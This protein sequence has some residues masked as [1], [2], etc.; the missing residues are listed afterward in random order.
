MVNHYISKMKKHF[1]ILLISVV[2]FSCK[3][4]NERTSY[5]YQ[6]DPSIIQD[7]YGRQL[8]FHGLN[9]ANISKSDSLRNPWIIE[10]DVER[11]AT[12]FGFNF[13]RYLIFWDAIEPQKD[14]F[15]P[16]Y[17]DRVEERVNWYTS[18][19]MYVMLD[20]HQDLYSLVFG[21]DG[22]PAWAIR[23]NGSAPINLPGGT[24][25][26]LKN[27]DP[28]VV[29]SWINFWSY[30]AHKDL[31]DHYILA[32]KYVMERFKNNPYVIGYDLM[33]EPWGGD[34]V[35]VFIT[36]E[37]EKQQLT[38][39]YNKLIPALR[40]VESNKYFF[41]EPTPAPVTFGA[42]SKLSKITDTR[43][44]SKLVYA[45]HCYPFDTHEGVGYT[46]T[47]K[48]QLK[49]WER[50]RK[51]DVQLHNNVP[52][53]VGEFGLSP[54]Q[55]GFD[56]NLKD[57]Y[58]MADRNQ[59]HW[60]YWSNDQG[61]WSPINADRTETPILQ[62]LIRTYPKATAGKI[63]TFEYNPDSK[64]FTMS[65]TSNSSIPEP[66]EIF[67]PN[68]FYPSGWD[69]SVT[70][71]TNYTQNFDAVKQILDFNTTENNKDITITITPK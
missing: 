1:L 35:K 63:K 52:L 46:A 13:V 56:Q 8:I 32:W 57:F 60:A 64:I 65:F 48:Q 20:M 71:T 12:D 5:T 45:P 62:Y 21:G 23:S 9:T 7:Q 70:G 33:N 24:P 34:L 29:N 28:A 14:V 6:E 38:A 69:L 16:V 3:K 36:G 10:S 51:K 27:I 4:E 19:G 44:T 68:R 54:S 15:D 43:S 25:W 59:W 58:A 17:L 53:L 37:F 61:G 18:R 66:T 39:F 42:P 41:F 22:A 47:A 31:Q 67:I 55:A 30:T 26:W 11:E 2:I 50:E 40:A 49:D